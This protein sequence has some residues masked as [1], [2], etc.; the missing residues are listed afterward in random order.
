[1]R[2]TPPNTNQ[3]DETSVTGK[4]KGKA[5]AEPSPEPSLDD[6]DVEEDLPPRRARANIDYSSVRRFVGRQDA[7]ID[8]G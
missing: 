3:K 1:M 5:A 6:S 8:L 2:L 7:N 4:G